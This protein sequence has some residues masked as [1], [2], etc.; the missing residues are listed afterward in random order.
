[1]P[2]FCRHDLITNLQTVSEKQFQLKIHF[3]AILGRISLWRK[4]WPSLM[5]ANDFATT[6]NLGIMYM[7]VLYTQMSDFKLSSA[8]LNTAILMTLKLTT[9]ISI[10]RVTYSS[11]KIRLHEQ[12]WNTKTME[13]KAKEKT[14]LCPSLEKLLYC[15]LEPLDFQ[16]F[17]LSLCKKLS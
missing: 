6:Q 7:Y 2:S 11:S 10:F 17:L 16:H 12:D 8:Q 15:D 3:W 13:W 1:M 14:L 4:L 9:D 5:D